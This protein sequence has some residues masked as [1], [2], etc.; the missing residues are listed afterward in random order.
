VSPKTPLSMAK[1]A[2]AVA[3]SRSS[4]R[5][6]GWRADR[7]P[8][9]RST[10]RICRTAPRAH[11]PASCADPGRCRNTRRS[12]VW[13]GDSGTNL[14]GLVRARPDLRWPDL[15]RIR[16]AAR[17][18]ANA[19]QRDRQH[20][21]AGGGARR[22]LSSGSCAVASA[23]RGRL[24][25]IEMQRG[26]GLRGR[27]GCVCRH[28]SGLM[29]GHGTRAASCRRGLAAARWWSALNSSVCSGSSR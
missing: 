24:I 13:L 16:R 4:G 18:S 23:R 27:P 8:T 14:R 12:A 19:R 6:G 1:R 21:A 5:R 22:A 28:C 11:C 29:P 20:E 15:D 3:E 25:V 17:G 10:R 2:P 26:G 9:G 7:T